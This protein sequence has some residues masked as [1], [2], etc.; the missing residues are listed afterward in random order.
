MSTNKQEEDWE[1]CSLCSNAD[2]HKDPD[3]EDIERLPIPGRESHTSDMEQYGLFLH[4]VKTMKRSRVDT[5]FH[6]PLWDFFGNVLEKAKPVG[7]SDGSDDAVVAKGP[8]DNDAFLQKVRDTNIINPIHPILVSRASGVPIREVL[9]ELLLATKCGMMS[10]KLTPNCQRCGSS[11]CSMRNIHGVEENGVSLY[12]EGCRYQNY[13]DCL[14]KIKVVFVLSMDVLYVLAENFACQPSKKS[15]AANKVFA[16][17]PA[18]FSGTAFRYSMGCGG[19]KMLRDALPAGRYRMHCPVS[20]TDNYLV[21]GRNAREDDPPVS[22]QLHVSDVVCRKPNDARKTL[23]LEHGKIHLDIFTDTNSFFVCWI[24]DDLDDDT[25]LALPRAE[26]KEF[27]NVQVLLRHPT[28]QYWFADVTQAN[29]TRVVKR[30]S[31]TKPTTP[32]KRPRPA[33][34]MQA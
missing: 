32:S 26:R 14:K 4:K 16:V 24:Q 12:C 2:D 3:D 11:V 21:V 31:M 9:T 30:M 28:Y 29:L 20:R 8:K 25:L 13:I 27:T 5:P 23:T 22:L 15:M 18:T 6:K 17:V 1:A 7:Y 19:D 10:M 34:S 33:R